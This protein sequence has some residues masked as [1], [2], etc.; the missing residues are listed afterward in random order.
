[1]FSLVGLILKSLSAG[2]NKPPNPIVEFVKNL[3]VSFFSASPSRWIMQL[4]SL[5]GYSILL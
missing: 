3:T 4:A 5:L 1:M 2:S